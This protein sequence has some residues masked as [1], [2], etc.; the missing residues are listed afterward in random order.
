[1]AIDS[2]IILVNLNRFLSIVIFHFL[3]MKEKYHQLC[4]TPNSIPIFS[5][6]WWLNIVCS[7]EKWDVLLIEEKG[8]IKAALPIYIPCKGIISMPPM[9]Q[10][11]GPWF[12]PNSKDTKYTKRLGEQ[13]VLS[14]QLIEQLP[15]HSIF[16]QNFHHTITDWLPFYWAGYQQTTRYTYR[17]LNIKQKE[18]LWNNMS[19][20]IRRNIIKANEKFRITVQKGI[21][22]EAFLKVQ[23]QT[24]ER[25]KI[26]NKTDLGVLTQLI[27]I[28]RERN[29]GDLWGGYDEKGLL[30][31][32]VF[33]VWQDNTAWYLAG[34]GNP[35]LRK[36]GAHSL[37][38]WEAIHHV[39]SFVDTF[40]FEGSMIPGVERFFR[41][42]G[43]IQ[44][45]Y[46]TISK[47]KLSLIDRVRIKLGKKF[48]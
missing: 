15:T 32:A 5:Q 7:K 23:E 34:G 47:G 31:A 35:I 44:T 12:A 39:S 30:H 19:T 21:S 8:H 4:N 41:E 18:M 27:Q 42:F 17:L 37:V 46:F 22:I 43:A 2:K 20:N 48:T 3:S 9:T 26:T 40:D 11:M 24:F 45:P 28:C 25:Q 10:T 38:L 14:K 1:M 13:Q 16:L 6:D 33:I 29:Q 36:S